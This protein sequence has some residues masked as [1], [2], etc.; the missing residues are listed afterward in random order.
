MTSDANRGL[1][2]ATTNAGNLLTA[3]GANAGNALTKAGQGITAGGALSNIGTARTTAEQMV[4][5]GLMGGGAQQQTQRQA[6]IDAPLKN[7][8]IVMS[9]LGMSPYG[10]TT[11][12][13]GTSHSTSKTSSDPFTSIL[14]GLRLGM[15]LMNLSEDTEKTDKKKVGKMPGTN[16]DLW[17]YRYKGDPKSY[18]KVVGLMASD[19]EKKVPHA[20]RKVGKKRVVDYTAAAVGGAK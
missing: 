17:A 18:P 13:D 2:A 8:N 6:E 4:A 20:V 7:L 14:G 10:S 15:G 1:S 9:A 5:Q 11:T 3:S 12:S 19:V 16:L